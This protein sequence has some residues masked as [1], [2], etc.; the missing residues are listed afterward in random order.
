[1]VSG[2]NIIILYLEPFKFVKTAEKVQ[3][4]KFREVNTTKGKS[5]QQSKTDNTMDEMIYQQTET[6][7]ND[8][9]S[10]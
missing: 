9:L 4:E 5:N 8:T 3:N 2:K 6:F 10:K 1:M 7:I